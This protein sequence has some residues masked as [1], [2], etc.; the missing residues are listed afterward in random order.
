MGDFLVIYML[1]FDIAIGVVSIDSGLLSSVSS[2]RH[3]YS[4]VNCQ[5]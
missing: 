1:Y 3:G 5:S 4:M 2:V